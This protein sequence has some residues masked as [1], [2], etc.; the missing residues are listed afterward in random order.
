MAG[1]GAL[2][3]DNGAFEIG[4][5]NY[6]VLR[7]MFWKV[8]VTVTAEDVGGSK[9]RTLPFFVGTGRLIISSMGVETDL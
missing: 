8:G 5:R 6:S 7:K 3:D 4:N 9:S 1:G 2:Y